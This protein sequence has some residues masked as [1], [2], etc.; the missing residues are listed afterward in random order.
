M[1]FH[2]ALLGLATSMLLSLT[3]A[4]G[5]Q[6]GQG[7]LAFKA[8]DQSSNVECGKWSCVEWVKKEFDANSD[9][10]ATFKKCCGNSAKAIAQQVESSGH[11]LSESACK[12]L[13]EE[14]P[15]SFANVREKACKTMAKFPWWA[16]VIVAVVLVCLLICVLR[17][18]CRCLCCCGGK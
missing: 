5:G 14:H 17:C 2:K 16:W 12:W 10:A 4:A 15:D 1:A 11:S 13:R 6:D 9:E 18:L 7:F 3:M 8:G